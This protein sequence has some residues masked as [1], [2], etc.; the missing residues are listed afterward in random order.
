MGVNRD[1]E[2]VELNLRLYDLGREP[3]LREARSWYL[4]NFFPASSI[5]I[6]QKYRHG[7]EAETYIRMVLNYSNMV[8]DILNRGLM[9]ETM[10][11]ENNGEM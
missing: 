10:F 11:S 3:Q 5:E 9:D 1:Y 6:R 4:E 2:G 8:A 7:S